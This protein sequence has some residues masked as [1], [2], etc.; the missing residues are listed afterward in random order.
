[1]FNTWEWVILAVL[2]VLALGSAYLLATG[3]LG[4]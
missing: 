3:R 2:V 4:L 1:V